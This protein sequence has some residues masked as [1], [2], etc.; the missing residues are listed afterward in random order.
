MLG[1]SRTSISVLQDFLRAQ[2]DEPGGSSASFNE[3]GQGLLQVVDVLANER[4]LRSTLA[5]PSNNADLKRQ[6]VARLF[7]TQ[8]P[9]RSI[10]AIDQVATSRWSSEADM[11]DAVEEAGAIS[12]LMGAELDGHIDAV[13]EELFRFGRAIDANASLQMALTDPATPAQ[14]KAGIVGSLLAGKSTTETAALLSHVSGSLR[15]RRIQDAVVRL[16]ELAAARRGRIIADVRSAIE[17]SP[18]QEARLAGALT[19]IHGHP[20]ELNVAIDPDVIGGIDVRIGDEVID[21]TV[22][23]KLDQA[24]RRLAG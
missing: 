20:V 19:R 10:A 7:G 5:D 6:I 12:I 21:G 18:E 1:A 11:V 14:E 15:G 22:A 24:R 13:E 17:L 23:T 16:S 8:L 4:K 3:A 2:F 9:A